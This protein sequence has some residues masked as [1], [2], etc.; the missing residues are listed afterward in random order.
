MTAFNTVRASMIPQPSG[1]PITTAA[2]DAAMAQAR[3]EARR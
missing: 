1:G 2:L 3:V